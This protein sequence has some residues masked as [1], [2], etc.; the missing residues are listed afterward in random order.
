M[1]TLITFLFCLYL[2]ATVAS[3]QETNAWI[4]YTSDAGRYSVLLPAEPKL[5]EQPASSPDGVKFTQ[6]LASTELPDQFFMVAY[7]DLKPDMTF[8]LDKGR[9]GLVKGIQ[10]TLISETPISLDGNPGKAL[11]VRA[12]STKF[13]D[14][15]RMYLVNGRVYSLQSLYVETQNESEFVA[16]AN[17]FFDSFSVKAK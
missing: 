1:K 10:G 11:R 5:Q 3:G 4:K 12:E 2:F 7:F 13:I 16:R 15:V 14:L 8:S 6:Y 17:K 9:D